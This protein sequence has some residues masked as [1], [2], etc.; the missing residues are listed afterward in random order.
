M[1]EMRQASP[2]KPK[3]LRYGIPHPT[4]APIVRPHYPPG[5]ASS[6]PRFS[7]HDVVDWMSPT[8]LTTGTLGAVFPAAGAD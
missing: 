5:A 1:H 2:F 3:C 4:E 6:S 7:Y 8:L